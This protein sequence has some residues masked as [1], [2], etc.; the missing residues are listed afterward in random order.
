MAW[1]GGGSSNY[2]DI[3]KDAVPEKEI[4][5]PVIDDDDISLDWVDAEED[6]SF[7]EDILAHQEE[8]ISRKVK[9]AVAEEMRDLFEAV[10]A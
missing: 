10:R 7:F 1:N 9:Q 4:G 2:T 5:L 3:I 8:S 6:V